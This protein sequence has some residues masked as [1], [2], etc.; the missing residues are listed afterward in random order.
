[1]LPNFL[2]PFNIKKSNLTRIGPKR[3]GGYV[4]D[5]RAIKKTTK[6]ITCG[7]NDDWD[8]EIDF[9]KRNNKCTIVAYDH[10]VNVNF[11]L[12]RLKK[13]LISALML[14][15]LTLIKIVKIFKYLNY[16]YFFFDKNQHLKK[17][18]VATK[19]NNNQETINSILENLDNVILKID[20]ENDEYKV[21]NDIKKNY[22]KINVLII[23]FHNV[24]KNLKKLKKFIS[25]N[26]LKIIHIHANNFGGV[27][28]KGVPTTLEI[29]F[30][31]KLKFKISNK[32]TNRTYPVKNL[33][34]KNHKSKNEI[35]LSF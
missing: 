32:K 15:K 5:K 10:T 3:D 34:Y 6:I 18:I 20:I 19:K 22:S 21:L 1:M 12:N 14:K 4:I 8:F 31:N 30:L 2:R 26:N 23:E 16:K 29:T 28:L 13:D 7:L 35:N 11:W 27:D 9:L 24:H 33:D 17:K 25:N